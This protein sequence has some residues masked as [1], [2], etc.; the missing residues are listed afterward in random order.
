MCGRYAITHT[1]LIP[2]F[3]EV[4]DLKI[5]PRY[6]VA[7]TQFAPVVFNDPEE[8]RRVV[9]LMK[10][11]M[12]PSWSRDVSIGSRMINARS[13]TIAE[14]PSFRGPFRHRRCLIPASGFFEWKQTS[15]GKIP[16]YFFR[17]KTPLLGLAGVWDEYTDGET[18][19]HSYSIITRAASPQM[20]SYHDRMPVLIDSRDFGEWLSPA[21]GTRQAID[22]LNVGVEAS[23]DV[24]PVSTFVNNVRNDSPDCVRDARVPER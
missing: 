18:I 14:K 5:P 7:P 17:T 11:G 10:W 15:S 9:D 12:V 19:L 16:Y 24:H 23:F 13:E 2:G 3:F 22:L 6:N 8:E 21:T 4:D 20:A 1:E